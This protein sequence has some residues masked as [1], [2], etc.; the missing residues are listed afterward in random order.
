[1]ENNNFTSTP[2][3]QSQQQPQFEKRKSE[4]CCLSFF[5]WMFTIFT[6]IFLLL[7]IYIITPI[8]DIESV[9]CK[10]N[11]F[12]PYQ[13][14]CTKKTLKTEL[15]KKYIFIGIPF[16]VIYIILELL[17]PTSQF[18]YRKDNKT[19][20]YELLGSLFQ[21]KPKAYVSCSCFHYE[22]K[23][24]TTTDSDGNSHTETTTE[25][26]YTY[27][28]TQPVNYYSCRDV[29]GLFVLNLDEKKISKKA[30]IKL[31]IKEEINYADIVSYNDM[32]LIKQD[33]TRRN[34]NK[35]THFYINDYRKLEGIKHRYFIRLLGE[36]PNCFSY[37]WFV[38]FTFLTVAQFYKKYVSSLS[39]YQ[40]FTIRKLI[41][42]RYDLGSDEFNEKYEKFNPQMNI[43]SQDYSYP[44]NMFTSLIIENQKPLPTEAEIEESKKHELMIPKYEINTEADVGRAGT[45]KDIVSCDNYNATQF[46]QQN[47]QEEGKEK[48]EIPLITVNNNITNEPNN[49]NL[50]TNII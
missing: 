13:D 21:S 3:F 2:L 6:W 40:N 20:L 45:V 24:Y 14:I 30:Y 39:I 37:G 5:S 12:W 34:E 36:E 10:R 26:V 47:N 44:L 19:N 23:T 15:S 1:M 16:Y 9:S 17:S 11:Y 28:E 22:T 46:N 8:P 43:M 49:N 32:Y 41:S 33:M 50:N 27:R 42:T 25:T 18:L 48:I 4:S 29:S 38:L 35:D 7:I 31:D